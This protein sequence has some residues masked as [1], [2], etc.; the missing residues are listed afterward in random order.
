M[1][2]LGLRLTLTGGREAAA[3]LITI[4][5]AVA[6]GVVLLLICLAGINAVNTQNTRYA[7]LNT[8]TGS[9][10][11]AGTAASD[12]GGGGSATEAPLWWVLRADRYQGKIIGRIDIAATGT[13]SPTP[14]GIPRQRGPGASYA[15]P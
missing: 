1:I 6:V 12:E 10:T 3:R 5:A 8:G 14:P 11:A 13:D 15:P 2:W 4:A 9:A 7:W